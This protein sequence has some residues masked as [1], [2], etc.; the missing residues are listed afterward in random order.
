MR[1]DYVDRGGRLTDLM[2]LPRASPRSTMGIATQVPNMT[3]VWK[4]KPGRREGAGETWRLHDEEERKRGGPRSS[5]TVVVA[6]ED[7][8]EPRE[9][10]HEGSQRVLLPVGLRV[11]HAVQNDVP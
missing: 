5:F 3:A 7:H 8:V 2:P 10:L 11:E 9:N 6:V 1:T 4:E